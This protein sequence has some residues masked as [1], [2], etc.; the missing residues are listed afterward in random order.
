MATTL[1]R[2]RE[3]VR[4]VS[5][6]A[7]KNQFD[8]CMSQ[9][10]RAQS[11][12]ARSLVYPEYGEP[13][14]VIQQLEQP[15]AA[16]KD[17][18]VVLR[19]L[20]APVNP[21]DINTIQ[22]A[23]PLKPPLPAVAGNEG[24][25]EVVAT[26]GA[27]KALCVGDRVV[28]KHTGW[29]TWRTHALC[30]ED[31]LI[32]ISKKLGI[33]EA[34]T[35]TVNPCTAYRMLKDFVKL[36]PGDTVIQNAGNSACGQYVIQLCKV[37]GLRSINIVRN[38]AKIDELKC[39]LTDLGATYVITEEE[40]KKLDLFKSGTEPKPKL[41]LNAV[42]GKNAM[43]MLRHL[44]NGGYMVTYGGMSREPVMLPTSALIFKDIRC[45][46]YWMSR[47]SKIN[48]DSD[49]RRRMFDELIGLMVAKQL[50]APLHT[51]IPFTQFQEALSNTINPKGFAGTKYI[52]DFQ[53]Q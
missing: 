14:K 17:N 51:V 53:C 24:V 22:G 42:G 20:A 34:A 46:G 23:Y 18:E 44:D 6:I 31:D 38:R 2:C 32:K 12:V 11:T 8:N 45:V 29:G 39:F 37:W 36:K 21:A 9:G 3:I 40:T 33:I 16:P 27:V 19:M 25:G 41:A 10:F 35:L 5:V 48:V 1:V 7:L 13:S 26:G 43:E 49:E 50:K 28:P 47:W 52:L 4:K 30:R 15:L